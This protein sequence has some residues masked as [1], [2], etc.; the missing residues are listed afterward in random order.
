MVHPDDF[1]IQLPILMD[2]LVLT[3]DIGTGLRLADG[4]L[5]FLAVF[6]LFEQGL[7][8]LELLRLDEFSD[9]LV[10][11]EERLLEFQLMLA[12]FLSGEVQFIDDDIC[13]LSVF[14]PTFHAFF[15]LLAAAALPPQLMGTLF[16]V[17]IESQQQF[18][19]VLFEG[20]ADLL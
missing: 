9:L 11:L 4:Q 2:G 15:L 10:L 3:L 5:W 6:D 14:D 19:L 12:S 7:L 17:G 20:G 16:E 13:L 1:L 8:V 18:G